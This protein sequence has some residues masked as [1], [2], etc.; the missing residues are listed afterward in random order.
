MLVGMPLM[1]KVATLLPATLLPTLKEKELQQKAIVLMLKVVLHV[2]V[3][4][5]PML[6][7][8]LL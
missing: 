2:H 8:V 5:T 4:L 1:P 6:K 3:A 7:V